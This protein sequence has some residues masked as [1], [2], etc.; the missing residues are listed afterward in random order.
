MMF[1]DYCSIILN[2]TGINCGFWL[3]V[4]SQLALLGYKE[5]ALD[6]HSLTR[7]FLCCQSPSPKLQQPDMLF[8]LF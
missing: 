2:I 1:I 6:V 8:C 7:V 5:Y 4:I 3:N